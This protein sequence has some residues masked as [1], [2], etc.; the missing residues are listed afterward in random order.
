MGLRQEGRGRR[1]K[2]TVA[3]AATMIFVKSHCGDRG[4]RE[5][6]VENRAT[7][8]ELRAGDSCY[9]NY[10]E[11]RTGAGGGYG[12]RDAVGPSMCRVFCD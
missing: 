2:V 9:G 8:A 10:E 11:G 7:V 4:G 6:P 5:V 12:E 1:G 3:Q